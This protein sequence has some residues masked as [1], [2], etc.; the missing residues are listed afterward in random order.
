PDRIVRRYADGHAISGNHL[1]AEAAHA[2]AELSKYLVAGVALHAVEAAAV[3]RHDR[4]LHV[5]QI[6]LAQS[7]G[8]PSYL[9]Q[10]LCHIGSP[11]STADA[12]AR[13]AARNENFVLVGAGRIT[14]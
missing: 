6:V 2:A 1:D 3:H 9:R 4:A 8:I 13:H 5:D 14:G 10:L 12:S 7:A 11:Q